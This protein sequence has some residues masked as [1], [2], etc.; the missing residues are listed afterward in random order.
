VGQYGAASAVAFYRRTLSQ[1]PDS[2][3]A[4][5]GLGLALAVEGDADGAIDHFRRALEIRHTC[6]QAHFGLGVVSYVRG[7]VHAAIASLERALSLDPACAHTRFQ[8]GLAYLSAGELARGW[9]YYEARIGSCPVLECGSDVPQWRGEPLGGERILLYAEQGLG[10]TLQFVR[11]APLVAARGGRVVLEVQPKLERLLR[12]IDGVDEI[13][14]P[15]CTRPR[16]RW[17]SSLLSLPFAFG[18]ELPTIPARVPYLRIDRALVAAWSARLPRRRLTVGVV[19][20]GSPGHA[21][22]RQRSIP[23]RLLAPLAMEGVSLFSLQKGPAESQIAECADVVSLRQLPGCIDD[24]ADMAAAIAALD[25]VVTVDTSVAHL[26]GALGKP[27]WILLAHR[28]DWRWLSE[29]DD[30]PWYPTARLFRQR[31]PG[32]WDAVVA[33]LVRAIA[34]ERC[35]GIRR[36]SSVNARFEQEDHRDQAHHDHGAPQRN[37]D[38]R[39][40]GTLPG[41]RDAP[42][43]LGQPLPGPR[44]DYVLQR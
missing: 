25:L 23:L 1:A 39:D 10:D 31:A 13:I 36:D 26:A 44:D 18:T 24:F 37:R 16:V 42:G 3:E 28:P 15:G 32:A 33:T 19:W 11:Y 12:G 30:S 29:R 14:T 7:D 38:H 4:L 27:V 22:N 41:R 40:G 8:L 2:L 35:A 9:T 34:A 6:A 20:S 17:R 5:T 43:L 21:A